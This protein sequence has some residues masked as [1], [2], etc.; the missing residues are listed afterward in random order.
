MGR[1]AMTTALLWII[2]VVLCIAVMLLH[3]RIVLHE[4]AEQRLRLDMRLFRES[5][6]EL[7]NGRIEAYLR[8]S[9]RPIQLTGGA[10]WRCAFG[11]HDYQW[12]YSKADYQHHGLCTRC[13]NH[14]VESS[15][16]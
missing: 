2:I 11:W 9:E 8:R 1:A 5:M 12:S 10:G 4:R 14:T 6:L 7:E 16:T 15:Y 13:G 3:R